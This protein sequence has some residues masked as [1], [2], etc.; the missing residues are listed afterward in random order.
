MSKIRRPAWLVGRPINFTARVFLALLFLFIW[1][2][3]VDVGQLVSL[4]GQIKLIWLLPVILI[5]LVN[6]CLGALRLKTLVASSFPAPFLYLLK[7]NSIGMAA[8]IVTPAS[9]GGFVRAWILKQRYNSSFS[10]SFG[11]VLLDFLLTLAALFLFGERGN[12][13]DSPTLH[14]VI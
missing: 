12:L 1:L 6:V 11:F 7:L 5:F 2:R 9:A 4:L 8:S 13:V 14:G 10:K 3:F